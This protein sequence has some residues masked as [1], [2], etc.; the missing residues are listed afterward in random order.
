MSNNQNK[1]PTVC[2]FCGRSDSEVD[3]LIAGNGVFN[4]A[5]G[6]DTAGKAADNV[7]V[8]IDT[9][10]GAGRTQAADRCH[11]AS[12]FLSIESYMCFQHGGCRADL[13]TLFDE[14]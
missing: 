11:N 9:V 6:I 4:Q 8:A 5:F 2:S 13:F 10:G 7:A 14:I 3:R 12:S 1:T